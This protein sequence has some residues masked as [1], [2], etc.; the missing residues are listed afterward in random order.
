MIIETLSTF[1]PCTIRLW[2]PMMRIAQE[3]GILEFHAHDL[4]D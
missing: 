1:P 3:K 4:R 2:V